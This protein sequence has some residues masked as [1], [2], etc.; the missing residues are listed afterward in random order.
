MK[1]LNGKKVAILAASGF[2]ES[3]LFEP[4]EA[5]EKNGAKVFIVSP[6]KGQIKAWNHGNWGRVLDVDVLIDDA[7]IQDYDALILPGGV[8]NPDKLRRNLKAVNFVRQFFNN[9]K[10]VASI[11][12]GPQMLIEADVVNGRTMTS[13]PSIRKDLVNAGANWV[14]SEVVVDNNL[15]TSRHPSDLEAFNARIIDELAKIEETAKVK[16]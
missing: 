16:H 11:C 2:E 12:H 5:L 3:E 9:N 1:D 6:E 13:F 10:L 8:I 7:Q 4:K 15:L 14:D